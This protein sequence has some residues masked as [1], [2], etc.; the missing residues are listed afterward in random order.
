M[1]KLIPLPPPPEPKPEPVITPPEEIFVKPTPSP[2]QPINIET[3][4]II[5]TTAPEKKKKIASAKQAAHLERIRAKSLA[6]RQAK[7]SAKK[8]AVKQ[9]EQEYQVPPQNEILNPPPVQRR[10][11]ASGMTADDIQQIVTNTMN[12]AFKRE[13]ER[14]EVGR[15]QR[16]EVINQKKAELDKAKAIKD[17]KDKKHA[18]AMSILKPTRKGRRI[19]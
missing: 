13:H 3:N 19:Y 12:A 14:A 18:M 17:D 8:Q 5:P 16:A 9:V 2:S 10:R 15:K 1:S 4:E 7:A 11:E 6:A